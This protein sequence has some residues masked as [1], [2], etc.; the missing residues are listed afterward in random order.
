MKINYVIFL[1]DAEIVE[2]SIK[3]IYTNEINPNGHE[4]IEGVSTEQIIA[5][6]TK[7][8]ESLGIVEYKV[9]SNEKIKEY[10]DYVVT[11]IK[12]STI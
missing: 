5:S 8:I 9:L 7:I 10:N 6:I 1:K 11:T 4:I 3:R 12:V 2:Q